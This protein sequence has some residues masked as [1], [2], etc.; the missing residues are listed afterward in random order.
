MLAGLNPEKMENQVE[1]RLFPHR[2]FN[3][4]IAVVPHWI[5]LARFVGSPAT[6]LQRSQYADVAG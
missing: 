1:D 3:L 5:F 2:P 4:R 6:K